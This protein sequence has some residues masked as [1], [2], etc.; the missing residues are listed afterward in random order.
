MEINGL[1]LMKNTLLDTRIV[2]FTSDGDI[3]IKKF[4]SGLQRNP[5]LIMLKD[6]GHV[7]LSLMRTI[8]IINSSNNN[9]FTPLLVNFEAFTKNIVMNIEDQDHRVNVYKNIALHYAGQHNQFCMHDKDSQTAVF[10]DE[11]NP[12]A[13]KIFQTFL[14]KTSELISEIKPG[15]STQSN[16]SYNH[17]SKKFINKLYA[18]RAIYST[19]HAISILDR[20]DQYYFFD[21]L[22]R[23]KSTQ[24]LYEVFLEPVKR[25]IADIFFNFFNEFCCFFHFIFL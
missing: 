9:I 25:E 17:H 3:K 24:P 13:F 1:R 20:N 16:E 23:I 21:I 19:R 10:F 4:I 22:K 7:L 14:E 12:N 5:P 8:K 18:Y 6:P 2:S 15:I 11:S